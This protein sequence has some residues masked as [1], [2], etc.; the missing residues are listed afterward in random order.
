MK[1]ISTLMLAV[2]LTA[3]LAGP[4]SADLIITGVIDGPLTGGTAKAV[5][6]Y[7]LNNIADLS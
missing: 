6:L 7:A 5:E 4:A 2:I 1:K 3:G